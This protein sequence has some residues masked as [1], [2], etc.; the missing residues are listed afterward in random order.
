MQRFLILATTFILLAGFASAPSGSTPKWLVQVND[1]L[2]ASKFEVSVADYNEFLSA[3][4]SEFGQYLPDSTSWTKLGTWMDPLKD[5]Y[6]HHPAFQGYPIVGIS[7]EA[8]IAY[9]DWLTEEYTRTHP[10]LQITFRLP[11]EKEWM[12]VGYAGDSASLIPMT[13]KEKD[14]LRRNGSVKPRNLEERFNLCYADPLCME[15]KGEN[16]FEI[17]KGCPGYRLDGYTFTA[18]VNTFPE[19]KLGLFHLGGNAAE[20]VQEQGISKGGSW[21]DYPYALR[22]EKQG[23][24]NGPDA[25]VGFRVFA[26]LGE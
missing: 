6:Y 14:R 2:W 23:V 22:L 15:Y 3:K 18:P 11:T 16:E 4:G 9:C 12:E 7:H 1:N 19:S 13:G 10:N 25:K 21:Y 26:E 20:M 24:Y 5:T 8:A 17:E